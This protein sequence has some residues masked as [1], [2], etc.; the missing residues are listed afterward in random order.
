MISWVAI[1]DPISYLL[2]GSGAGHF[3]LYGFIYTICV[4]IM[5]VRMIIK[6]RHSRYQI[7][8]TISV[9]FFQMVLAFLLPELLVR[10][11][12]PYFD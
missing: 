9:M 12:Q 1:V 4:L 7:I 3:F 10:L 2:K 8:R 11:N 6:Y 5:G